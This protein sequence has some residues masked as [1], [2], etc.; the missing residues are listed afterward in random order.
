[1]NIYADLLDRYKIYIIISLF[2]SFKPIRA[3]LTHNLF[4]YIK[5]NE[6]EVHKILTYVLNNMNK[7]VGSNPLRRG[8]KLPTGRIL[9]NEDVHWRGVFL[10]GYSYIP[11]I[12]KEKGMNI[13]Q[14][15][16]E[17]KSKKENQRTIIIT[18][19]DHYRS[20]LFGFTTK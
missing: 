13:L 11:F 4:G 7:H 20:P 14:R 18:R 2:D 5:Y 3:L 16:E 19:G 8:N 17:E 9:Y 12:S 6:D 1:M 10:G 15:I